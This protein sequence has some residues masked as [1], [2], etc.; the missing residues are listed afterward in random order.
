MSNLPGPVLFTTEAI[1]AAILDY[2]REYRDY[3]FFH[4]DY[5]D[6]HRSI[7]RLQEKY[8]FPILNSF[9]MDWI[10]NKPF[11]FELNRVIREFERLGW[12]H[13]HEDGD[14]IFIKPELTANHSLL[15]EG[16]FFPPAENDQLKCIGDYFI[17]PFREVRP[18]PTLA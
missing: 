3:R 14:F 18:C 13:W 11:C 7:H 4:G 9:H 15:V 12:V 5:F 6:V 1:F 17:K 2:G 10:Q 16:G 8:R